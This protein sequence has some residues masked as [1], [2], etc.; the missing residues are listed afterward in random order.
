VTVIET[1][2]INN[3]A[4][5]GGAAI[6]LLG[7]FLNITTSKVA[8]NFAGEYGAAFDVTT[9]GPLSSEKTLMY[10][11]QCD[12]SGNTADRG[13]ALYLYDLDDLIVTQ[14]I[15]RN[16]SGTCHTIY[17]LII[18]SYDSNYTFAA[19][20]GGAVWCRSNAP[21][22]FQGVAFMDNLAR[23]GGAIYAG[24]PCQIDIEGSEFTRNGATDAGGAILATEGTR[25]HISSSNFV[26]N[27]LSSCDNRQTPAAGG[28]INFGVKDFD[29]LEDVCSSVSIAKTT[30]LQ[31]EETSFSANVA[32]MAGGALFAESGEYF[33]SKTVF[34]ANRAGTLDNRDGYGGAVALSERCIE[35]ECS[36]ILADFEDIEMGLNIAQ[37][38]GGGMYVSGLNEQSLCTISNSKFV[39]NRVGDAF[40]KGIGG[41]LYV[42]TPRINLTYVQFANNTAPLGGGI[43]INSNFS[44]SDSMIMENVFMS[45]NMAING[46]DLYWEKLRSRAVLNTSSLIS[47]N[48]TPSSIA[49]EALEVVFTSEKPRMIRSGSITEPFSISIIDY[50]GEVSNSENGDCQIISH[51][52][53]ESGYLPSVRP[54]GSKLPVD[55]GSVHFTQVQITGRIGD[56]YKMQILCTRK[57]EDLSGVVT[58]LELPPLDFEI[59][60]ADCP[61]GFAPAESGEGDICVI[62]QYG[63]Y[64]FDGRMCETCPKGA[65]C[66]G[67]FA[68]QSKPNWWRSSD[69]SFDFYPCKYPDVCKAGPA[70]GDLACANGH[71][72]PLCG[73]CKSGWF[74]FSGKCRECNSNPTSKIFI[75][76]SAIVLVAVI[77]LLF[78]RSWEFGDPASPG[79][80]SKVKILLMHFQIISLLKQYDILWPPETSEGFS[81]LS[82]IDF[83]P[84]MMAPEC[85]FGEKYNFWMNWIIQMSLPILVLIL[86]FGL[87]RIATVALESRNQTHPSGSKLTTWL[88]GLK[89]RCYKNA[90]WIITLLYPGACFVALQM[91]ARKK[92]DIGTYL[93]A[94]LSIKVADLRGG[95]TSTYI[96]YMVPGAILLALLSLG[97]PLFC[98]SAIWKH[99]YSLDEQ[100]VAT[101]FGFLYGSYDRR[102]PYW[103]TVQ[104][105][106]RFVFALIPVFVGA[107]ASGSLQGTIAQVVAMFLLVATVWF[108]PFATKSDNYIEIASQIGTY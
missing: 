35:S 33:F 55:A 85:I 99:R 9:Q 20:R 69:T 1:E 17:L 38:A 102:T 28:A 14:S 29:A 40:S 10:V 65:T 67:G 60:M 12:I 94:D 30:V 21:A 7:G 72:G 64:N 43:Y 103:E 98:F 22:L 42:E 68:V 91:F 23:E 87:Y 66:P 50:Y 54:L 5:I 75:T 36:A 73:V 11:N 48:F 84:S 90:Y 100:D 83:G 74:E 81:W 37:L 104:M 2:F 15:F 18:I 27:G 89:V 19:S 25:V 86:C 62:C 71:K 39:A 76:I 77:I 96:G 16:N 92:L 80:L 53:D 107:N 8:E 70:A 31:V 101:R 93:S 49:T 88:Q 57:I 79:L 45:A 41:G 58:S 6:K 26:E 61:K 44:E 47:S 13:A 59:E 56:T 95:F 32:R 108:M 46:F 3:Y 34:E 52:S 24:E 4:G 106:R 78:A 63:S 105:L 51:D 97:V 82:V